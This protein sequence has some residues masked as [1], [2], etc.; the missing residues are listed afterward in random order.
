MAYILVIFVIIKR[1]KTVLSAQLRYFKTCRRLN[2]SSLRQIKC[3]VC[4]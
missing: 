3:L 4:L 2:F 1:Q